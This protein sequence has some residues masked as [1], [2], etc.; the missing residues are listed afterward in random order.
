MSLLEH[1]IFSTKVDGEENIKV[2]VDLYEFAE[3][4]KELGCWEAV[5]II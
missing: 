2:G 4:M 3:I 5:V 1:S